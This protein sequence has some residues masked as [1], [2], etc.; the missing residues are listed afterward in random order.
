MYVNGLSTSLPPAVQL[1]V[2]ADGPGAR[3]GPDDSARIRDRVR[4]FPS[5]PAPADAGVAGLP[6]L[7]FAGQVNGTTGYEEAAGQGVLAGLNA[8]A[9][10]LDREPVVLR[11]DERV[12]RRAGGRSGHSRGG[13]ALPALHLA[14]G[15]PAAA[16]PGQRAAATASAGHAVRPARSLTSCGLAERRLA[17]RGGGAAPCEGNHDR[18]CEA[19]GSWSWS[20]PPTVREPVRLADL[21][22]RPGVPLQPYSRRRALSLRTT[23]CRLGGD[24]VEIRRLPGRER[25]AAVRLWQHG[26]LSLPGDSGLH[27]LSGRSPSRP[28]RSWTEFA[29]RRW[30]GRQ[31]P[32]VSPSDLQNLVMEV[33]RSAATGLTPLFH[34]KHSLTGA[35]VSTPF[36]LAP[37]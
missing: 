6:G 26:R 17:T 10:A 21:A 7:F 36:N 15:V 25:T 5:D 23:Q 28:G 33:V 32:G 1:D 22:R 12:H 4:L 34:V 19:S 37:R 18:A 35:A 3:A 8:A 11:R 31:D 24:R 20:D 30:A 14:L 2:P 9:R 13:R 16:P 29:R 27:D